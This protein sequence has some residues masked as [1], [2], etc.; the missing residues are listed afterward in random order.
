MGW[1]QGGLLAPAALALP[2]KLSSFLGY[3]FSLKVMVSAT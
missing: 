2:S 3:F 1:G